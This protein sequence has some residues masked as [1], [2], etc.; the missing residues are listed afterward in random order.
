MEV[1][2]SLGASLHTEADSSAYSLFK[3]R[4]RGSGA[5][6]FPQPITPTILTHTQN[7]VHWE[8][9]PEGSC[10]TPIWSKAC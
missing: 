6:G 8:S 7:P 5:G 9:Q 3:A 1:E 2:Q 10:N 4:R